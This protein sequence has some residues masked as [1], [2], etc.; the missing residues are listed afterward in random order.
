VT[1][2]SVERILEEAEEEIEEDDPPVLRSSR[3][4]AAR[5]PEGG[6]RKPH[7]RRT[8]TGTLRELDAALEHLSEEES[9][10]DHGGPSG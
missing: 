9:H 10:G 1:Q 5:L 2:T 3:G 6:G 4:S 8:N 7:W